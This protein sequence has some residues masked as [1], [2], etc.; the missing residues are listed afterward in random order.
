[1]AG[2]IWLALIAASADRCTR[3]GLR[4]A[5][6]FRHCNLP[7]THMHTSIFATVHVTLFTINHALELATTW[8]SGISL[9][10]KG[11]GDG[12]L[13]LKNL[14][15]GAFANWGCHIVPFR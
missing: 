11:L 14:V 7:V 10:A 9:R 15:I 6:H 1:L 3:Y 12:D 8:P 5:R 13:G 2:L 4:G